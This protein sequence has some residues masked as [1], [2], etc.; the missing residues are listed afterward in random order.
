MQLGTH[1]PDLGA[2][3]AGVA[4]HWGDAPATAA[5]RPIEVLPDR[6]L[7]SALPTPAPTSGSAG[8][9]AGGPSAE[10]S[11][12]LTVGISDV[13]LVPA[14]LVLAPGAHALLAGPP[15]SGRTTA[16]R[17]L[18]AAAVAV[19]VDVVVVTPPA[20][21]GHP[22][23]GGVGVAGARSI[24][25]HDPALADAVD[26][27]RVLLLLIDDADLVDPEHPVL[28]AVARDR[29]PGRHLVVAARSD[30]ARTAYAHWLR[31]VRA[32]R[33]GLLLCPDLDLDG[34]LTGSRLPRHPT[35]TP[36]PGRGW[37]VGEPEGFV[38]VA[39]TDP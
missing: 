28:A 6:V 18:G 24:G 8:D 7:R 21:A 37:L 1:G 30:R 3:V 12:R 15:R 27:H 26:T 4:A 23:A 17:S 16:L 22:T 34:E 5:A 32:D 19:G 9:H 10:G 33:C 20:A 39:I 11:L 31:E 36:A 13:G 25:V 35:V 29:R 2:A 14:T 38:Q